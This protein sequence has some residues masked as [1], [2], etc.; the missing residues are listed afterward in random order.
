MSNYK[1]LKDGTVAQG[2]VELTEDGHIASPVPFFQQDLIGN[3]RN[4]YPDRS[5]G[6]TFGKKKLLNDVLSDLWGGPTALYVF[7][8]APVQMAMV[9]TSANDTAN[10]TGVRAV[11][12]HYLDHNYQPQITDVTLNGLTPVLTVPTDILRVNGLH[13]IAVGSNVIAAGNISLTNNG[14]TYGFIAAGDNTARQA[15]FTVPDGV[16]GYIDHWQASSGSSGNHF[17]QTILAATT[18]DG[19]I[20][21]GVFLLQDEQGT[22]NNG[23]VIQFPIPIPIPPKTDVRIAAIGDG[24]ASNITAL[25]AIMGWFEPVA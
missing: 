23:T 17:C 20:F 8:T 13:A 22:Q 18:H 15:I 12:V 25:G 24:N 4:Y 10:G 2:F 21:P 6:F 14:T 1:L 5:R 9:S 3:A 19:V 16:W 7:P 11:R